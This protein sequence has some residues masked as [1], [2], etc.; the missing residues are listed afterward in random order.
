MTEKQFIEKVIEGGWKPEHFKVENIKVDGISQDGKTVMLSDGI[1]DGLWTEI[2]IVEIL[3]SKEAWQAV[4]KVEG[5]QKGH[6]VTYKLTAKRITRVG[7]T[8]FDR[9][10]KII[11]RLYKPRSPVWKKK[12]HSMIDAIADD[13]SIKEYLKTL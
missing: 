13:K 12:M 1:E 10:E 9:K 2:P 4:G 3:L 5:W 6:L 11:S 8:D 7:G